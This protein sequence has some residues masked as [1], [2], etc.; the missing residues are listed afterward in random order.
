MTKKEDERL[1]RVFGVA[2]F[3]NDMGSDMIYPIWPLFVTALGADMTALGLLDG[4]G[5]AIVSISQA[6]SGYLSDKHQKKRIFIWLGYLAGGVSRL[7]YAFS[8]AWQ[9][10][11]PFKVLDRA[12]KMRGAPRD[13]M[14]AD[15]STDKDRGANFGFLRMMD[16]LGATL[17]ILITLV[18]V[19]LLDLQTIM[20]LAAIPS[21][22]GALLIYLFVK[23]RKTHAIFKGIQLKDFSN[24]YLF[25]LALSCVFALSSFSYSFLLILAK[26]TGFILTTI[27]VLYLL[28]TAV[29]AATSLK[30]GQLADRLG[31]KLVI[32]L[33]YLLFAGM[34]ALGATSQNLYGIV[35]ATIL[36]GLHLGALPG[37]QKAFV[38]ELS[39]QHLRSS[40]LGTYQMATGLCALPASVIAGLLWETLGPAYTFGFSLALSLAS[41][42]LMLL[43]KETI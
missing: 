9:W 23:E 21:L 6:V 18:L 10:L 19:N 42:G 30:F 25:F 38:A 39:P 12:G 26:D 32:T 22:V 8:K 40:L 34:C 3:L 20:M 16:N 15:A 43:V 17:G 33:S 37:V 4:L 14:I 5:D 36:Y 2:S 1:V 28:F 41:A 24:N 7:G 11:I 31:R 29:A 27:P 35:L 13:A